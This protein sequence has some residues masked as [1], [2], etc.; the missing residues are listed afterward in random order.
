M[1]RILA[2]CLA[3]AVV[4]IPS[5][6]AQENARPGTGSVASQPTPIYR[7]TVVEHGIDAVNYQYRAAPTKIDFR[8]TVLLPDAK[9]QATVQSRQGRT[10][11]DARFEKLLPPT[12]FGREYLTY[13]LWALSPDGASYNI[14]EVIP[15]ASDH[16]ALRVTADLQ[17]FGMIIT[18]EPYA[19]VR[20][21]G[22]V[23]VLE[24]HARPDTVGKVQPIQPKPELMPRG[25]Y[26]WQLPATSDA[27]SNAPK[28]SMSRYEALLQLY[29]A[30]NAVNIAQ[31]EDAERYAPDAFAAAQR[32]LSEAQR[33]N[34]TKANTKLVVQSAREAAQHAED[35]RQ[36][37]VKKKQDEQL[38]AAERAKAQAEAAA[39]QA[40]SEAEAARQQADRAAREAT[41]APPPP[42][43]ANR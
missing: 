4:Y 19:S 8:G 16:A 3:A 25:Q 11:I 29:Q 5:S 13:V 10:E 12:R 7:V 34:A 2:G 33:L 39:R 6:R 38:A 21:P 22:N 28:V 37:A 26:T 18:A 30:Q 40:Q 27:P 9:G 36:I 1:F 24:N 31:T 35:A 41:P 20:Q 23:V 15:D 14:G 42:N 32:S 17:T 43:H